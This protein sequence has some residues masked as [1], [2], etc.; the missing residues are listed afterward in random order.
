MKLWTNGEYLVIAESQAQLEAM[1]GHPIEL[2][3]SDL[4]EQLVE[5]LGPNATRLLGIVLKRIIAR[6]APQA[7]I[8]DLIDR[9]TGGWWTLKLAEFLFLVDYDGRRKPAQV[10]AWLQMQEPGLLA[11]RIDGHWVRQ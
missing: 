1:I 9:K 6:L 4:V 10:L 3:R 7:D 11:R 8:S 5:E 2:A